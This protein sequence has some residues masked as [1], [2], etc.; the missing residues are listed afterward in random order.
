MSQYRSILKATSIFGGT[1]IIQMLVSIIRG[2][3]VALLIGSAGMGLSTMYM[4]TITMVITIFGLGLGSS[5]VKDLSHSFGE[6]DM[7]KFSVIA[8][9]YRR[10]LIFLSITGALFVIA[11][12][13]SF[14]EWAFDSKEYRIEYCCLSLIV[15]FSLL[16][17]RN[18]ALLVSTR[19][20]K[21]IAKCNVIGSVISLLSCIPLFYYYRVAGIVPGLI[22]STFSNYVITWY[23][24]RRI[25]LVPCKITIHD[26]YKHG[27]SLIS[28]GFSM[29]VALLIGNLTHYGINISISRLGGLSDL[30]FYNS[31]VGITTQVVG[32]V[33]AAMSSD[34][35]PRLVASMKSNEKMSETIN[36]QSEILLYLAVPI[37]ITFMVIAPVIIKILL[38]DEFL[39]ITNFIRIVCFGMI[40]KVASYALGTVSFA[41]GDK[42]VY[43]L[44]EAGYNNIA[45][46]VLS[47]SFYYFWGLTGLAYSFVVDFL[48]YY[49]I[50]SIVDHKIYHY[51]PSRELQIVTFLSF[52]A[53]GTVLLIDN[54]CNDKLFYTLSP[55]ISIVTIY[56]FL[57]KLNKK[58]QLLLFIKS[59]FHPKT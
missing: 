30:G 9:V 55:I 27:Y 5:V 59:K 25:K 15:V 21:D 45:H 13:S 40:L 17:S 28:L 36:E 33:F 46:I 41:K 1:Q 23:F 6:N 18:N 16:S 4:S 39:I 32:M 8:T 38:S 57:S 58:T 19:R 12:S 53:L 44:L 48:L 26:I 35:F 14:S 3:I 42:K 2:K 54:L 50:I 31:A 7:Y 22:V 11:M 43:L 37:L 10:L 51:N 47:I 56:Y 52:L 49:I 20:I 24:S 34:Y 29:T